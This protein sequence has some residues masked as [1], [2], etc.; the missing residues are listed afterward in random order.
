M[1]EKTVKIIAV[2]KGGTKYDSPEGLVDSVK[3][4]L[5]DECG[6]NK[7]WVSEE[8]LENTLKEAM[9]DYIRTADRPD[10]FLRLLY[11]IKSPSLNYQICTAF[12]LQQ[13]YDGNQI[14]NGFP[15]N[16]EDIHSSLWN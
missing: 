8:E 2:C 9:F 5:S 10:K 3:N 4:Y 1:E 7:I 16:Y 13:I 11:S 6:V 15:E 14:I 12:L